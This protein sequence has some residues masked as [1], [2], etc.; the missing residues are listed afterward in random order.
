ME[1]L[2]Q[3]IVALNS[4]SSNQLV[5]DELAELNDKKDV[6]LLQE[7]IYMELSK[8]EPKSDA[9]QEALIQ[10]DSQLFDITKVFIFSFSVNRLVKMIIKK[11]LLLFC[12]VV[13]WVCREIRFVELS[14]RDLSNGSSRWPQ[15]DRDALET[16]YC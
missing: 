1:Y 15:S 16:N 6:A 8:F 4:A 9:V 2:T 7:K 5:K 3:A 12:L 13:L 11:L 14:T 10:L